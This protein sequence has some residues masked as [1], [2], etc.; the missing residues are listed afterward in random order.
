MVVSM[1]SVSIDNATGVTVVLR[2]FK[3]WLWYRE[4]VGYTESKSAHTIILRF[5]GT[6]T[7]KELGTV[8]RS[9]GQNPTEA[10]LM[11][12]IQEVGFKSH[13]SPVCVLGHFSRDY[14]FALLDRC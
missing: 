2:S 3:A 10:E 11:D 5:I 6:I 8:M 12:M 9:L 7:T 13:L 14:I 1:V 4:T